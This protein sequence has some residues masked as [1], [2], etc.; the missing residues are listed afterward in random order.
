[1]PPLPPPGKQYLKQKHPKNEDHSQPT[2]S[3]QPVGSGYVQRGQRDR[4]PLQT[5]NRRNSPRYYASTGRLSSIQGALPA[6]VI[7]AFSFSPSGTTGGF[8]RMARMTWAFL[9]G[10]PTL[11]AIDPDPPQ[12]L[13]L[14]LGRN[15][16]AA[17]WPAKA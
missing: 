14:H 15:A 7:Q 10:W 9:H 6:S 8:L 3:P 4:Q 2:N 13:H 5:V 1:M 17:N 11:K 12:G 16:L